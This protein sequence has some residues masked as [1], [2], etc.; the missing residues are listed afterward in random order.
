MEIILV[1]LAIVVLFF[2]ICGV[3]S[4]VR[5]LYG[6]TIHNIKNLKRSIREFMDDVEWKLTH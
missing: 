6:E 3:V 2:L 1:I 4:A 5:Y